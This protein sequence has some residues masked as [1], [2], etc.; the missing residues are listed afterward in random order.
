MLFI[1]KILPVVILRLL[2]FPVGFCYFLFSKRAREHS[3]LYLERLSSARSGGRKLNPIKHII[4]FSLALVEKIEAW[5]GRVQFSRIHFQDDDMPEFAEGLERGEG[6]F[7]ISSHL[8]NMEFIR[9]LADFNRT[10]ISREIPVNILADFSVTA[11]FSRMLQKLNPKSMTRL[12]SV[13]DFGPQAIVQLQEKLAAG[14]LAVV[15]GDRTSANTESRHLLFPFLGCDAAFPYGPFF[16]AALS[17][18]TLY[19]VFAVRQ[20]D[21]SL[22]SHYDLH[23]HKS[24]VSFDCPR[25]ERD[26]RIT[27]LCHWYVSLLERYC[28]ENPY[29]W[30]NFY[31]FWKQED[32]PVKGRGRKSADTN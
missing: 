11:H 8:G 30:Y 20:K 1:F 19:T 24:P 3:R 15:A 23:I 27:A 6:I 29:Q 2:C 22:S 31:D 28:K 4:A 17:E 5:S 13:K 26:S 21:L 18:A 10:G 25:H 7:L 12:I 32:S 9:A 14:E 16:L